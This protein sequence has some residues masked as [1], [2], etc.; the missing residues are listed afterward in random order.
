MVLGGA[1]CAFLMPR[2]L[3]AQDDGTSLGD[4][5]RDLRRNK[6]QQD[7]E[8]PQPPP[9]APVIDND[10]LTQAIEDVRRMKSAEKI[11]FS[12]NPDGKSFRLSSPDVNCS[13]AFNGH[14]GSLLFQPALIEELPL[15][16]LLKIDGPGSIEA[17]TL[18]LEV[19]NG[20]EWE[21]R[22][23]TVGI[24]LERSA[25]TNAEMSAHAR[26]IPASENSG[27]VTVERRSD[28][29]L[30]FH[31]KADAKPFSSTIFRENIGITPSADEDWRWSV[32]A[33]KGIRSGKLNFAEP[34]PAAS[35][36]PLPSPVPPEPGTKAPVSGPAAPAGGEQHAANP[37]H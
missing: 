29:T 31:L 2:A 30:L 33:A 1:F 22:E 9:Q 5:A 16:D 13:L 17:D 19:L 15:A 21:L 4:F 8:K 37:S 18:Q 25:G 11:V 14:N 12:I 28:M 32:V 10:N 26:V 23:I 36:I 3:S 20:T 7:V 6:A 35:T 24:T 27:A 34:L